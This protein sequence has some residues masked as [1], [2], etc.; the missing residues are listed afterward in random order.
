MNGDIGDEA[1]RVHLLRRIVQLQESL[2]VKKRE[3][4]RARAALEMAKRTEVQQRHALQAIDEEARAF[5]KETYRTTSA[6]YLN[7][8]TQSRGMLS[9]GNE[10]IRFSGWRGHFEIPLCAITAVEVGTAPITPRAGIPFLD[11]YWPGELQQTST[12]LLTVQHVG[13]PAPRVIALADVANA[14]VWPEYIRWQQNRAGTAAASRVELVER[15]IQ[16]ESALAEAGH[17]RQKLQADLES[18]RKELTSLR[19]ELHRAL[20][21]R[22]KSTRPEADAA[23]VE[24]IRIEREALRRLNNSQRD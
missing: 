3:L 1:M 23:L 17:T 15:R 14:L 7:G 4:D 20:R 24:V 11:R 2:D 16:A 21:E 18:I 10:A 8:K 6:V 19:D 13:E 5:A 22:S 12:L 9:L